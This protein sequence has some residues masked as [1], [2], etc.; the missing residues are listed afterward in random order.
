MKGSI[1]GGI[2]FKT[3]KE[4]VEYTRNLIKEKGLYIFSKEDEHFKF[5]LELLHRRI[6]EYDGEIIKFEIEPNPITK[7]PNHMTFTTN[8][9]FREHFS[10]NKCCNQKEDTPLQKLIKACRVSIKSQ[11]LKMS[12]MR[13]MGCNECRTLRNL[14]VDHFNDFKEIFNAFL[15]INPVIPQTFNS[16]LNTCEVIFK[17]EDKLFEK[18]FQDFHEQNALLQLLCIDCHKNKLT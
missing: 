11:I 9:D 1:V 10:W 5:F 17:E 8:T 14:Q 6:F 12:A 15:L 7:E 3:K 2:K 13:M 18:N 4:L 16:D